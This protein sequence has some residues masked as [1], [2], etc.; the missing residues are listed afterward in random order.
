[1]DQFPAM[2]DEELER[3]GVL[4]RRTPWLQLLPMLADQF[5]QQLGIRRIILLA[6]WRSCFAELGQHPRVDGVE[7]SA[8]ILQE[9]IYQAAFRLFQTDD[10]LSPRKS[11]RQSSG[12]VVNRFR[13]MPYNAVCF[14]FSTHRPSTNI[15]LCVCPVDAHQ[16]GRLCME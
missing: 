12:P 2:L 16:C 5:Q 4:I 10:K 1:M 15:V 7:D 6:A 13:H 8:V 3:P 9:R 14:L 11:S